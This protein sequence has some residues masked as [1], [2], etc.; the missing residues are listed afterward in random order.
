[1][2]TV[3]ELIQGTQVEPRPYQGRI[4]TKALDLFLNKNLRSILIESP[5]GSGKTVMGLLIAQ[6]LQQALGIKVG[7]VAMRRNLLGLRQRK[8]LPRGLKL[9][10]SFISMFEKEPPRNLDLLVVDEAQHDAASSMA[11]LHSLIQAQIFF[12]DFQPRRFGP[13]RSNFASIPS[14]ATRGFNNSFR[15]AT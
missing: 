3:D 12:R 1:M 10:A 4:V 7:W 8:K 9:D 14:S 5:T 6:G 13:T 15:K 11:N 2:I